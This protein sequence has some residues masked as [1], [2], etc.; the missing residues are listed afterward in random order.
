M[1]SNDNLEMLAR[2]RTNCRRSQVANY[3]SANRCSN[4]NYFLGIPT[5]VLSAIVATGVFASLGQKVELYIQIGVGLVG[6]VAAV[7]SSLQT[8]LKLDELAAKHRSIAAEYGAIKRHLDQEISRLRTGQEVSQQTINNIR[9]RMDALSRE[10]PVVPRVVWRK[11]RAAI[12]TAE[13]NTP[14]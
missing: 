12:P 8:F 9:E 10:G 6:V 5:V 3:E 4:R 14:N 7:L 13:S 1:E 2:W 11:A